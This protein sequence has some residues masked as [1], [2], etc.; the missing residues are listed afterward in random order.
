MALKKDHSDGKFEEIYFIHNCEQ[1]LL[2]FSFYLTILEFFSLFYLFFWEKITF[3]SF[4][5]ANYYYL[6][7]LFIYL[8]LLIIIIYY[9]FLKL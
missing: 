7:I 1:N 3:Y 4:F 5:E 8:F 9:L 2:V 6:F